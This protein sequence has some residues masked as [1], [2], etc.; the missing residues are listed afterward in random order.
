MRGIV[1]TGGKGPGVNELTRW[2]DGAHRVIAAD[3]GVERAMEAGVEPDFVVGDM[4]SLRDVELLQRLPEDRIKRFP[5]E[6][7]NTDTEL[8]LEMLYAE[9]FDEVVLVGGGGGRMDHLIGILSLFH[10]DPHP[11]VWLTSGNEITAVDS[12]VQRG[13]LRGS[14]VSF[15]PVGN[16]PCRMRSHGLKWPLD[17][18]V[19]THGDVGISNEVVSDELRVEMIAGRLIMVRESENHG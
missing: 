6:K 2:A 18:L 11:N 16:E 12:M 14:T 8:A 4:D 15:F 10:R 9:Q 7:D 13:D 17:G 1:V 19:W 3:T 5:P